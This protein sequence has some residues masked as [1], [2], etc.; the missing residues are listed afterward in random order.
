MSAESTIEVPASVLERLL[1]EE[2][3]TIHGPYMWRCRLCDMEGQDREEIVHAAT[4]WASEVQ[5]SIW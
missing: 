3:P 1:Y 4:C 2:I 5:H